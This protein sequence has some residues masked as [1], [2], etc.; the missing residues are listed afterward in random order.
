LECPKFFVIFTTGVG[1]EKCGAVSERNGGSIAEILAHTPEFTS[2]IKA[3]DDCSVGF[4]L[5]LDAKDF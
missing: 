5:E 3:A 4:G 2:S 1:R